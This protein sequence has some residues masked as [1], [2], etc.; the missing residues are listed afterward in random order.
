M[1]VLLYRRSLDAASGA[2]QLVAAQA[3]ALQSA[4]AAVSVACRRGRVKF[5]LRTGLWPRRWPMARAA[6][7]DSAGRWRV[8]DHSCEVPAA[9]VVFV[10]NLHSEANRFLARADLAPVV[11]REESFFRALSDSTP[12]VANSRLVADALVRNFGLRRERIAV[13]YPGFDARRFT[14]ARLRAEREHARRA[15][16]VDAQ[17]P[18]LGF[19]TSGD[20][21]KRGLEVFLAAAA[22]IAKA[23]P[24]VGFLVVGSKSLPDWA[25]THALV[26][27]GRVRYRRKSGDPA[28]WFAAL[29]LF[30]YPALF[31][32]FGMVVLEAQHCGLPVLT[33]RRVGA[34]EC[35][36]PTYEKWLIAE[37]DAGAFAALALALLA[38]RAACDALA[39]QGVAA[40]ARYGM[41][42]HAALAAALILGSKT[43]A[44]VNADSR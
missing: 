18:L 38:D 15:L 11:E 32:E 24:Q 33:S 39:T 35:L 16:D 25:R 4:G 19:V 42:R 22:E 36:P 31:E 13:I 44:E 10:H 27:A 2:G 30:L 29:D 34:A 12:V 28:R 41:P 21:H 8:I 14:A 1:N 26:A 9:D 7:P 17:T 6:A 43:A 5:F 3:R 23:A 20:F 37:P 40:A